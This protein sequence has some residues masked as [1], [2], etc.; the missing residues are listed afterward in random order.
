MSYIF[1]AFVVSKKK[2]KTT[3]NILPPGADKRKTERYIYWFVASIDK[4][5]RSVS[6]LQLVMVTRLSGVQFGL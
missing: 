6:S 3:Y 1:E 2:T 5:Q 4:E